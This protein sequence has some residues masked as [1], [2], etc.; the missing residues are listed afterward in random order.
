V[1]SVEAPASPA[2]ATQKA[3]AYL[4]ALAQR[5][6]WLGSSPELEWWLLHPSNRCPRR[7]AQPLF[8][9]G[10]SVSYR[11]AQPGS[12][13][14]P[15]KRAC[16]THAGPLTFTLELKVTCGARGHVRANIASGSPGGNDADLGGSLVRCCC[17]RKLVHCTE[18]WRPLATKKTPSFRRIEHHWVTLHRILRLPSGNR[19][20]LSSRPIFVF[21][22]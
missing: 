1:L 7:N 10:P 15:R 16:G 9:A 11:A 18:S 5:S 2:S 21:F 6:N 8:S 4:F 12:G 22:F 3:V 13:A 17:Y 20:R 19:A 14:D